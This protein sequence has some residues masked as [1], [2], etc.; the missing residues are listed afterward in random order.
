MC[1]EKGRHGQMMPLH[2]ISSSILCH[3]G[4]WVPKRRVHRN[5][6]LIKNRAE[7][8]NWIS[9]RK[10]SETRPGNVVSSDN[11]IKWPLGNPELVLWRWIPIVKVTRLSWILFETRQ[12]HS[13]S[14]IASSWVTHNMCL[15]LPIESVTLKVPEAEHVV[16]ACLSSQKAEV[17]V[18]PW[19]PGQTLLRN[20]TQ[21]L[22]K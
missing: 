18:G 10:S 13:S 22:K 12:E 14:T 1:V 20:E 8:V 6:H 17:K 9:F 5:G 21:S 15:W 19:V 16:H 7:A 11:L 2:S 4:V 3:W